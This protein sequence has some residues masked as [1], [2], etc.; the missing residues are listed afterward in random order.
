MD[1]K[2][3][4]DFWV[5]GYGS[6]MWRP[7]FE[8]QEAVP[9]T[10]FGWRRSMCILSTHYRGR[11]ERPGLVLGLDRG[12]SCRG[13]AFRVERPR[14]EE[15]RAILHQREMISGVYE[16]RFAPL[17]LDD[18]RRVSGYVFTARRDHAQ[19]AGPLTPER[20]AALIRQGIGSIGSSRDYLAQT[21]ARLG[22]L[23]LRDGALQNLLRLVDGEDGPAIATAAQ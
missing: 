17:R 4:E 7:D 13:L 2:A 12:G 15:V 19:Y 23:G 6:L 14:A 5:F 3:E 18:G 11:P 9:A 10:L 16:P 1:V 20:A 21:V 8:Y 22:Q